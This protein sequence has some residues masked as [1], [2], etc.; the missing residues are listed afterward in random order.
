MEQK[1]IFHTCSNTDQFLS[2][3]EELHVKLKILIANILRIGA[4]VP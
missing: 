3:A 1:N 2:Q 4:P